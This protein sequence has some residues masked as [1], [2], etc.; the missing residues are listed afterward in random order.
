MHPTLCWL[1]LAV[2]GCGHQSTSQ[3]CSSSPCSKH[4][5][6]CREWSQHIHWG[7]QRHMTSWYQ[8]C[9]LPVPPHQ[10]YGSVKKR[11]TMISKMIQGV[12]PFP[13]PCFNNN[14]VLYLSTVSIHPSI[15]PIV[16][17]QNSEVTGNLS[18][19]VRKIPAVIKAN[20]DGCS[21]VR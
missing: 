15:H 21:Y 4:W 12:G 5:S 1:S 18:R 9:H 3:P 10:H 13:C 16:I 7:F 11:K 6:Q 20:C 19:P 14:I 17:I 8:L 2:A